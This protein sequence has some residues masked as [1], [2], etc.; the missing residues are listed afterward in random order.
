MKTVFIPG[1]KLAEEFHKEI[2]RP[3]LTSVFPGLAY[4]A[5]LIG[6]GSEVLG[7]DDNI[8]MDHNWGPRLMLFLSGEDHPRYSEQVRQ[9]LAKQLPHEFKG[10]PTN[11]SAPTPENGGA[12]VL[13]PLSDGPVNHRISIH[14]VHGFFSE[15]LGFDISQA[16]E[17][18]DWLTFSEQRL[19]GIT[20]GGVFH[21][22][23][24]LNAM[25]AR[26]SYYPQDVWLYLLASGWKRIGQEEHL[27]GR[28][29]MVGDELGSALIGARLVR[30]L[31]R[32]CFLMEKT[33]PP[34]SKWF[35]TAFKQLACGPT[36][37]PIFQAALCAETWQTREGY[38][39]RAYE[40]IA[41]LHNALKITDPVSEK[42]TSFYGRP[43]RVIA[44]NGFAE[45]L[46]KSIHDPAVKR[47]A[48]RTMIGNL[49]M[50]SDNVDLVSDSSW[51]TKL[52]QFYE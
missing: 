44:Q 20:A 42:A 11:F 29:G 47:I 38:L 2:V 49:D 32:L 28:A 36:L 25:R 6:N 16:L 41:A 8:S 30:D 33:Y 14:T 39:V 27:M 1:L 51:R 21:D 46:Q 18:V 5:A 4:T 40:Y 37:W 12:Q 19:R 35:G 15:Y 50:V 3:I 52:R 45:A 26:F 24:D 10:Y 43:F 13:K 7:F 48:E 34:Y 22:E 23:L 31:M 9:V 17:P